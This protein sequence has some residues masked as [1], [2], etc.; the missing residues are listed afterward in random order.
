MP[1]PSGS[2]PTFKGDSPNA[3]FGNFFSDYMTRDNSGG[4]DYSGS[5]ASS[6]MGMGG[7]FNRLNNY[8]NGSLL[9]GILRALNRTANPTNPISGRPI[10]TNWTPP[11][12]GG[13]PPPVTVPMPTPPVNG[14]GTTPNPNAPGPTTVPNA[15]TPTDNTGGGGLL[16][17]GNITNSDWLSKLIGMRGGQMGV[18][19]GGAIR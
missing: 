1:A 10:D 15:N 8:P 19:I 5:G 4:G 6:G 14:G 12:T 17:I 11:P 13:P 2:S 9:G 18:P 16:N 7:P 3:R